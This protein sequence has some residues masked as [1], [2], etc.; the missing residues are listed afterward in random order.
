[1]LMTIEELKSFIDNVEVSDLVLAGRLS[2][3]ELTIRKATNNNFL[4]KGFSI[5]ADIRGGVFM[6]ESLIPFAKGDTIMVSESDLQ[7]DCLAVVEEVTDDTTFVTDQD[8]ADDDNVVVT[9]VVYPIDVKVAVADIIAW[10]L[11]N[12]AANSGD[13]SKKGIQSETIS[14][15]S[16]TYATD[17]TEA[18]IDVMYGVPKKLTAPLRRYF[19]ARF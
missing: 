4:H 11:K 17:S 12:A 7:S 9:K 2:A 3:L 16:V 6:S 5:E 1:M 14:R 15:Y 19:K 10:Q 8:W 18:D 13:T